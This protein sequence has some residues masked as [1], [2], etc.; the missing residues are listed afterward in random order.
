MDLRPGPAGT[1]VR[2]TFPA[3]ASGERLPGLNWHVRAPAA[4]EEE[5]AAK[6]EKGQ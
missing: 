2:L 3:S 4:E 5:V 6:K 1:R